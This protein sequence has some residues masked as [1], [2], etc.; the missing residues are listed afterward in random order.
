MASQA[1][2]AIGTRAPQGHAGIVSILRDRTLE[3]ALRDGR[4]TGHA[5]G[6]GGNDHLIGTGT[7]AGQQGRGSAGRSSSRTLWPR[8]ARVIPACS[9][10]YSWWRLPPCRGEPGPDWTVRLFAADVR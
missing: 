6:I 8:A 1:P 3:G 10:R 4:R 2:F 5:V 9:F 7:S